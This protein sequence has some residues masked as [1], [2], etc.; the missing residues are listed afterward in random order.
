MMN[1]IANSIDFTRAAVEEV[2]AHLSGTADSD[3]SGAPGRLRA[4]GTHLEGTG[5]PP[6]HS[7]PGPS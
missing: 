7:S 1:L 5:A 4:T 2:R 6:R 3:R